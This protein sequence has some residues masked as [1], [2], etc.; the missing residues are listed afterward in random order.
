MEGNNRTMPP[1]VYVLE[2]HD[3]SFEVDVRA[4]SLLKG[5]HEEQAL[6]AVFMRTPD[7]YRAL[8]HYCEKKDIARCTVNGDLNNLAFEIYA[9]QKKKEWRRMAYVGNESAKGLSK[10]LLDHRFLTEAHLL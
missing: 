2:G 5:I 8:V 4:V 6:N 10:I 7:E 9:E 1:I 3:T